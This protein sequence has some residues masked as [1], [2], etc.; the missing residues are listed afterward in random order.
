MQPT[1]VVTKEEWLKARLEL[2]EEE[3]AHSRRRDQIT[4]KRMALPWVK[5]EKDYTFDGPDGKVTLGDLFGDKSQPVIYHFMF[6]TDWDEGCKSC[7]FMVDYL[8]PAVIHIAHRDVAFAVVSI[9]P[10]DKLEAYRKR[11]GWNFLWV[12]SYGTDFNRDFHVSLTEEEAK[13]KTGYYNFR[14]GNSFPVTEAPGFSVFA[15]DNDGNVYHTYGRFAR[16]TEDFITSYN[17]LD[18]VPKGRNE[19]SGQSWV[20]RKDEYN[21]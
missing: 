4:A 15:K 7:S 10:F 3:K 17:L 13:N 6:A 21:D 18:L 19:D 16:G 2:L 1:N 9:A 12:S 5:M 11:M 8:D 14:E 20:Q